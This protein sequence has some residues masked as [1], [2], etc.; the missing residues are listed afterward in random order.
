MTDT[1]GFHDD[2]GAEFMRR[3][4]TDPRKWAEAF[5]REFDL[6]DDRAD[7]RWTVL[8]LANWFSHFAEVKVAEALRGETDSV[9]QRTS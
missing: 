6:R 7:H 4:G 1:P 9:C 2:D 8:L 5:W 3:V